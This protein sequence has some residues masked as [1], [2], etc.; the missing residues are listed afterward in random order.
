MRTF[1][2][3]QNQP[4]KPVSSNLA[5]PNMATNGPAHGEDPSLQLQR[6]IGNQAVL[7]MWQTNAQGLKGGLT[8]TA[9]PRFRHAF[10]RIPVHAPAPITMQPKLAV[11][12]P[13]DIYEQE[14]DHISEQIIRMPQPKL[15]RA[16][17]CGGGCPE[18]QTEQPSQKHP[19]LQTKPAGSGNVGYVDVPPV[20]HE[21]LNSPGQPLDS[22]TRAFMEPRL[23]Y[24]FSR[25]RVHTDESAEMSARTIGAHA[26][27]VGN[28]IVFGV[29]RPD[30]NATEGRRLLAHELTHVV[31]QTARDSHMTL[32]SHVVD[33]GLLQRKDDEQAKPKG[34][35]PSR[36]HTGCAGHWGKDTN[37]NKWGFV[38]DIR[39]YG[40]K[41]WRGIDPGYAKGAYCCNSWPFAVEQYAIN[42]LGLNGAA[43]CPSWHQREIATVTIAGK[44]PIKVLCSDAVCGPTAK[45]CKTKFGETSD[46]KACWHGTFTREVIEL[47]PKAMETLSG[48]QVAT[49]PVSVC[50]SGSQ[51]DLCP[52]DGPGPKARTGND[53]FPEVGDCLTRGCT[54]DKDTPKLKDTGWPRY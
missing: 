51:E 48:S 37:C 40:G 30:F 9:S 52:S 25:V 44:D 12:T 18:C 13:G 2:Q 43:S 15:Q 32:S 20:V 3:K 19:R 16:C 36:C 6:K 42:V 39:N 14:A 27:T 35:T 49:A 21:V 22:A 45:K 5:R 38:S 10:S 46:K 28:D 50:Y 23:G 7:R 24:D 53:N 17:A 29:G 4:Q 11:S 1:A 54:A 26:Y 8:G 34:A 47:S 31:Q 33:S 41:E